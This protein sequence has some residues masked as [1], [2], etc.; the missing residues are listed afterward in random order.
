VSPPP[1]AQRPTLWGEEAV[2]AQLLGSA[3]VDV[4]SVTA[5]VTQRFTDAAQF[6][7]L[8]LDY[9]GPTYAAAGRLSADG[10]A[11]FRNDLIALAERF[12][13][14]AGD[15]V[16]LDWEYRVVTA[17]RDGSAPSGSPA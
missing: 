10:R 12:D 14:S 6:A 2:V 4:R 15:G 7:D 5:S 9:Y 13:R 1:G 11:A 3:V 17:T 16:V 8:F